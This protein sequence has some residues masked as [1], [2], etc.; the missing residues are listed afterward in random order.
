MFFAPLQALNLENHVRPT[1]LSGRARRRQGHPHEVKLPKVL[2]PIAGRPMIAHVLDTVTAAGAEPAVV[3]VGPGMEAVAAAV[4][5]ED[6]TVLQQGQAGTADAVKAAREPLSQA[7]AETALVLFGDTPFIEAA[8]VAAMLAQR[9]AG[10]HGRGA[11]HAAARSVR[12][13]PPCSGRG[14]GN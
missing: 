12:L 9:D 7:G 10:A 6:N 2:H 3:V 5:I 14:A 8:T 13:W 1:L 4:A 11:W